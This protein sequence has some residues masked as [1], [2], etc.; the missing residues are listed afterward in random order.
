M[1]YYSTEQLISELE[2]NHSHIL[3]SVEESCLNEAFFDELIHHDKAL[4]S[5]KN[6]FPNRLKSNSLL[7]EKFIENNL[8][9]YYKY[10]IDEAINSDVID[11]IVYDKKILAKLPKL[12]DTFKNSSDLLEKI[13]DLNQFQ[14]I[15]CFYTHTFN[16][17]NIDKMMMKKVFDATD[18]QF[19]N[20]LRNHSYLL[21]LML[22]NK[23]YRFLKEFQKDAFS[24]KVIEI[25]IHDHLYE[26]L[27][28]FPDCI[29][30]NEFVLAYLFKRI[31][32][33]EII[34]RLLQRGMDMESIVN[35][36]GLTMDEIL[37][38]QN[39]YYQVKEYIKQFHQSAY[40]KKNVHYAMMYL[41]TDEIAH[42]N[43]KQPFEFFYQEFKL[44]N[45][46]LL[47][48][49]FDVLL[50]SNDYSMIMVYLKNYH[51]YLKEKL[52]HDEIDTKELNYS[53]ILN[54]YLKHN[55]DDLENK[56]SCELFRYLLDKVKNQLNM[57]YQ[58]NDSTDLL[59]EKI[60]L[61][62]RNPFS[63]YYISNSKELVCA[64][65][66]G[67]VLTSECQKS[68]NTIPDYV[69][70]RVNKRH[71]HLMIKEL[72]WVGVHNDSIISLAL[73]MYL[74]IGFERSMEILNPDSKKNYGVV[75][76][77]ILLNIFNGYDL[78]KGSFQQVENKYKLILNE[79]WI[80]LFMGMNYKSGNN[81]LRNYLSHPEDE[82]NAK[83]VTNA[84]NILNNW[85]YYK[86]MYVL[87]G[88]NKKLNIS[89]IN[90]LKE[91]NKVVQDKHEKKIPNIQFKE[92]GYVF[93]TFDPQDLNIVVDGAQCHSYF[94]INGKG[95]NADKNKSLIYY[96]LASA[97][98]GC[99][100]IRN[101]KKELIFFS[102]VYRNGNVLMINSM[103][104]G[105]KKI[106]PEMSK[107]IHELLMKYAK[108]I[109][110]KS[111]QVEKENGIQFVGITDLYHNRVN[112]DDYGKGVL[113][114]E[115]DIFH[116]YDP[117][118]HYKNIHTDL[119]QNQIILAM[120]KSLD[121]IHYGEV[122]ATY[123]YRDKLSKGSE[124]NVEDNS[125]YRR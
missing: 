29:K 24:P 11:T 42:L 115:E 124:Q 117:N 6:Y 108:E 51:D 7:L 23:D 79:E 78:N 4:V 38:V 63:I 102:P 22:K 97:Y 121:Y 96:C 34:I 122:L 26:H 116:I 85:P 16:K 31:E 82:N 90:R 12:S 35:E 52:E 99:V 44:R 21:E 46:A 10:F 72:Y 94:V 13:I 125:T 71:I 9:S 20:A 36:T 114:E 69:Y 43:V 27:E 58:D 15:H 64:S 95:D 67:N 86:K 112:V 93:H 70:E 76:E 39:D 5:L 55:P 80:R 8:D 74:A 2:N 40:T 123:D 47:Q 28:Y 118:G 41:T 89:Y 73:K 45:G 37:V 113:K 25:I 91:L 62:K 48:E 75:N 66:I 54:T 98:A 65:A 33:S 120:K 83:F 50:N 110:Q 57:S 19:P 84:M 100:E 105:L 14:Y 106:T 1:K 59:M 68:A 87:S 18:F 109:I 53:S 60:F 17:N 92:D 107:V 30:D 81:A 77:E 104:T 32:S 61:G 101:K 88:N 3:D 49:K 56:E 103:E 119:N 111:N